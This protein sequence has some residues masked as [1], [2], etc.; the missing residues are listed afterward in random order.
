[1]AQH[2]W[3][4]GLQPETTYHFRVHSGEQVDDN[5]G[6]LYPVTTRATELPD[7]PFLAFSPVQAPDGGA[8]VGAV[9]RSWL[10]DGQGQ[11]SEPLSAVVDGYGYW[12]LSMPLPDCVGRLLEVS[13]YGPTGEQTSVWL[14]ACDAGPAP[15]VTLPGEG[16]LSVDLAG[17]GSGTVSSLGINCSQ[18]AGADCFETY[19]EGLSITL[20]ALADAGSTFTGWGGA[21]SGSET[22][23]VTVSETTAVTATFVLQ[24]RGYEVYLPLIT[25]NLP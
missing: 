3:V 11:R 17:D 13:V 8:V 24:E 23:E 2:V 22:C 6:A 20:T 9:V 5:H 12:N 25:R 14:P 16:M 21:C 15:V 1:M 10:V 4:T 7:M 19:P 18:G